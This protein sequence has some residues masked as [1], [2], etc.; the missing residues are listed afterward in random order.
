MKKLIAILI[1]SLLAGCTNSTAYGPCVGITDDKDP[2]KVYKVSAWNTFL[3]V[4]FVETI[5][6]P[7]IVVSNNIQCPRADKPKQ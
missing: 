2:S 7:V 6:V 3:A 5:F 4:I 1:I